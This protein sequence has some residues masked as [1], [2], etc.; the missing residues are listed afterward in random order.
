MILVYSTRI[1]NRLRFAFKVI[2]K[3]VLLSEVE[4]T[5]DIER[6]KAF[7][8]VRISYTTHKI[9][10][11]IHFLSKPLLFET[12]IKDQDLSI[13]EYK[14]VKCFY[15]TLRTSALPFDPF[16]SAFYMTSRYEEYLPNIHDKYGRYEARESIATQ[17]SFLQ[18]PVVN[19]WAEFVKEIILKHYPDFTFP[20]KKYQFISTLDIDN[21][22]AYLEKGLVRTVGAYVRSLGKL[23]FK[24][25]AER[26]KV[27]LGLQQDPYDTYEF[28]KE[29]H[30]LYN[31]KTIYF[32]LLAD[33][34]LNDKNVPVESVKFKSLI[35]S[36]AD[37][38]D[39]GIHPSF[40][41]NDHPE[42]LE[43]EI[44]RLSRVI[45]REITKSR[46]HFLKLLLPDTYRHLIDLDITDDYTMGYAS[47]IG[48]RAGIANSFNFYDIDLEIE[49]RLRIHPFCLMDATFKY[50][51]KVEPKDVIGLI[52]PMVNEVKKL[53]GNLITLWHNESLS[54]S[55]TWEGWRYVYEDI[56][57]LAL[58]K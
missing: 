15:P 40:A 30:Q 2:F 13:F 10:S 42:K 29:I 16:A 51:L 23:D 31:I 41:S 39:V 35:K 18:V 27:L 46:Q 6:F 3:E 47:E 5:S 11:E 36:I 9:D 12:G 17:H 1:T 22:Y 21:A 43:K 32:F 26:T 19:W 44:K 58:A 50:Y 8:G 54:E 55:K 14:G 25:V 45:N 52:T 48:F 7:N 34:G 38:S 37:Y 57:K 33:Y 4:F 56:I 53:N 20:E 28:Q 24:E 49:T